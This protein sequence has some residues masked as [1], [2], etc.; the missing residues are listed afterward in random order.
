MQVDTLGTNLLALVVPCLATTRL[1]A[2]RTR[3]PPQD[4]PR[5]CRHGPETWRRSQGEQ[6]V[7]AAHLP[8]H[9]RTPHPRQDALW[10][11][12]RRALRPGL[13][14]GLDVLMMFLK[15]GDRAS[16]ERKKARGP[17]SEVPGAL[18]VAGS[19]TARRPARGRRPCPC[20]MRSWPSADSARSPAASK[21]TIY[22]WS[23]DCPSCPAPPVTGQ[24]PACST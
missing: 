24:A 10:V 13:P 4:P 18:A 2:R 9:R 6:T 17:A 16:G 7:G 15:V 21:I 14:G 5:L 3:H 19:R 20:L 1:G 23:S 22:S 8:P 12:M 11:G